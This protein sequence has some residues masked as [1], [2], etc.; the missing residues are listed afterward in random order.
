M[1]PQELLYVKKQE[2]M[3]LKYSNFPSHFLMN[4]LFRNKV[5]HYTEFSKLNQRSHY[6]Y[7][8][9]TFITRLKTIHS[10]CLLFSPKLM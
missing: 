1:E 4:R 3:D 8:L 2:Q 9:E 10:F 6:F 7:L 5:R